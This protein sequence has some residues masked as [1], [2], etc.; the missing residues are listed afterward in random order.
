MVNGYALVY[1]L[2]GRTEVE[3]DCEQDAEENIGHLRERGRE[4]E[5]GEGWDVTAARGEL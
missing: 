1:R 5:G 2:K 4:G 3:D